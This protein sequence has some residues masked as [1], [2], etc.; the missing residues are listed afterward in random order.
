MRKDWLF[1]KINNLSYLNR[2]TEAKKPSSTVQNKP[3][4]KRQAE[5]TAP[6]AVQ[7][8]DYAVETEMPILRIP[9]TPIERLLFSLSQ[10]VNSTAITATANFPNNEPIIAP[11]V[12]PAEDINV[13]DR[14]E[15]ELT[16]QLTEDSLYS[17]LLAQNED[18]AYFPVYKLNE[19]LVKK[20]AK[21]EATLSNLKPLHNDMACFDAYGSEWDSIYTT[22]F[23]EAL[24]LKSRQDF[25]AENELLK[26]QIS[27]TIKSNQ[28][29]AS[30]AGFGTSLFKSII[31]SNSKAN[32]LKKPIKYATSEMLEENNESIES[33]ITK[34]RPASMMVKYQIQDSLTVRQPIEPL[35]SIDQL[36]TGTTMDDLKPLIIDTYK[37][38]YYAEMFE[39][40]TLTEIS[41]VVQNSFFR[42]SHIYQKSF[43]LKNNDSIQHQQTQEPALVP[44]QNLHKSKPYFDDF[45]SF[46]S[47]HYEYSE[48]Y[49][50]S[51]SDK[52]SV[53]AL[54]EQD[55]S[56][57]SVSSLFGFVA[58]TAG[59]I[60][61]L[62]L[63][64]A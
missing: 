24:K 29:Q 53:G 56:H 20:V 64:N 17:D 36:T 30:Y 7:R 1:I 28:S 25:E 55:K 13:L 21:K 38:N 34:T 51:K 41:S 49:L 54:S 6:R 40:S 3:K 10:R 22:D 52:L 9:S 48:Y 18:I 31:R 42:A 32:I 58:I 26:L 44:V 50:Q 47:E 2:S 46:P 39:A 19:K 45:A 5:A 59:A 23:M 12:S 61:A 33:A 63:R 35:E 37:L 11:Y 62:L 43:V 15:Y 4:P 57:R 16:V 60:S 27:E 8:S 14:S